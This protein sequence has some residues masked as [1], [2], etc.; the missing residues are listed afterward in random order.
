LQTDRQTDRQTNRQTDV[1]INK[2]AQQITIY[3]T[4]NL[5]TCSI[6]QVSQWA[7]CVT[8]HTNRLKCSRILRIINFLG[9]I[10]K[11]RKKNTCGSGSRLTLFFSA[12]PIIFSTRLT[13]RLHFLRVV[14]GCCQNGVC[15][16]INYWKNHEKNIQKK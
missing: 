2:Q 11:R 13:V 14:A 3:V 9:E 4:V 15:C 1:K 6:W 8:L 5:T 7:S 16:H 12:D 10:F